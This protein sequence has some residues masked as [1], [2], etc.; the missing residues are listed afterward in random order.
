MKMHR[1]HFTDIL[2]E[3]PFR[4][5]YI[6]E[7]GIDMGSLCRD[8]FSAYWEEAYLKHFDGESLLI[9]LMQP[10]NMTDMDALPILGKILSHGFMTCGF[11]PVKVIF[12]VLLWTGCIDPR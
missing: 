8:L 4:I 10:C 2:K 1:E 12:R 6:G 7:K 11:L 5:R 3:Y 9:P